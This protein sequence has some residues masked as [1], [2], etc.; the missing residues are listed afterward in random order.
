MN[1]FGLLSDET[2]LVVLS[3]NY[4]KPVV[5]NETAELTKKCA[6]M[7]MGMQKIQEEMKIHIEKQDK[8]A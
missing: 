8:L 2:E 4:M 5:P 1:M 3:A 7:D 6:V